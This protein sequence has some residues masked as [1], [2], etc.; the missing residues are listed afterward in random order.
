[1][2]LDG[3]AGTFSLNSVLFMLITGGCF[4]LSAA[5][6]VNFTK[7]VLSLLVPVNGLK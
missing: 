2:W 1:V 5:V 7:F 4:C 6:A 3:L